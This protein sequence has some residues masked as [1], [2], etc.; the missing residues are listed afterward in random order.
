ML[1]STSWLENTEQAPKRDETVEA[2]LTGRILIVDD[3]P[4]FL[5]VLSLIL[6]G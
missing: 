1:E 4:H 6:S 5:R 2:E 3:D